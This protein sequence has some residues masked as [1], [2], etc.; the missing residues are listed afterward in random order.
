MRSALTITLILLTAAILVGAG[1]YYAT[2]VRQEQAL[3]RM[4]ET[5][6]VAELQN[7]LAEDLLVR[8]ASSSEQ[9][10]EAVAQWRSRYKYIPTSL[11][12]AD[13]VE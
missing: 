3:E 4:K 10:A 9:A 11:N 7:A 1:S 6:R 2:D 13:M 12:T 5:R 8:E